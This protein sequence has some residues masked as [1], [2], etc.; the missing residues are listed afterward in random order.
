M[1]SSIDL[2]TIFVSLNDHEFVITP[3]EMW[4]EVFIAWAAIHGRVDRDSTQQLEEYTEFLRASIWHL[5][6]LR[7]AA[8]GDSLNDRRTHAERI[9][10]GIFDRVAESVGFAERRAAGGKMPRG[11][12]T[13]VLGREELLRL[14]DDNAVLL[15]DAVKRLHKAP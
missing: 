6:E 15:D 11:R 8:R 12:E 5:K 14:L 2:M 3:V 7:D 13:A 1:R 9:L 4:H 10:T